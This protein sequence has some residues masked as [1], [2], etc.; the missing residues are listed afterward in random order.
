MGEDGTCMADF[1][2][3]IFT[4]LVGRRLV[5]VTAPSSGVLLCF[6]MLLSCS[7]WFF[8]FHLSFSDKYPPEFYFGL[9]LTLYWEDY[10]SFHYHLC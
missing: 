8:F 6:V 5:S 2:D 4:L 1:N 10:V 9:P 3:E 7:H